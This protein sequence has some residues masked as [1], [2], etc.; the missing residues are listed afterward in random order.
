MKLVPRL[1]AIRLMT[2]KPAL[3]I[4]AVVL[5]LGG[6]TSLEPEVTDRFE[7]ALTVP[8]PDLGGATIEEEVYARAGQVC[9]GIHPPFIVFNT[10]AEEPGF[11]IDVDVALKARP[12][13]CESAPD[14]FFIPQTVAVVPADAPSE[15]QV[16][17]AAL[18]TADDPC[19]GS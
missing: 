16:D 17:V 11:T 15:P 7:V 4:A 6:C 10:G 19:W 5:A 8:V 13:F 1:L 18:V 12:R 3:L 14:C 2:S 9:P